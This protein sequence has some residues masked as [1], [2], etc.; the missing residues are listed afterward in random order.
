MYN[1]DYKYDIVI[2]FSVEKCYCGA[3]DIRIMKHKYSPKYK[4]ERFLPDTVYVCDCPNC[5]KFYP[6]D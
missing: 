2:E 5:S 3:T 4:G 6:S 1:T